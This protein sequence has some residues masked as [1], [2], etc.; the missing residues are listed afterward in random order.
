M[1]DYQITNQRALRAAFWRGHDGVAGVTMRKIPSYSG[2]G[3]MYDTDTRCA[4]TDWLDSLACAGTISQALA[5]RAT[6]D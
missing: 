2:K 6:L 1:T 4:F 3:T 5:Q